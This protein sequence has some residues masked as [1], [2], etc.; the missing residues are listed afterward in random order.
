[1]KRRSLGCLT[2]GGMIAL[3]VSLV[4][5]GVSYAITG[6]KMF[7]PGELNA[8]AT[9][10]TLGGIASHADLQ[11]EC[12]ACHPA[13]WDAVTMTDLCLDCHIDIQESISDPTSLHGA[14]VEKFSAINCRDCHTEHHGPDGEITEELSEDFPHELVGFALNGHQQLDW[15]QEVSCLDCHQ[16]GYTVVENILCLNCHEQV[17]SRFTDGH[18]ELFGDACLDCH[19]GIDTYGKDF[20]HN[21]HP[22]PLEGKHI[23]LDCAECHQDATTLADLQQ[24][25]QECLACHQDR[26]VHEG[27]LGDNCAVCHTPKGWEFGVFDHSQTGFDL[28]GGHA[29]IECEDCHAD[30][31]YQGADPACIA[32]HAEDDQHEGAF[33]TECQTCHNPISWLDVTFDHQGPLAAD[34]FACHTDDKPVDHYPGICSACHTTSAWLPAT[35]DHQIAG[36]TDCVSCH[37]KD[38][39]GDHYSGQCSACHNTG[40]WLPASF[41]HAVAGATDCIACHGN[42]RPPNHFTGQCSMCHS[43]NA[44][45]PASF[46]HTFPLNHGGANENCTLCHSGG[47]YNSYTCYGCHEHTPANIQDK[48]EG[49]ANLNNCVRCHADGSKPEDDGDGGGENGGENNNNNND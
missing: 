12:A 42:Q 16:D 31:T 1:M 6:G 8:A 22:F 36:A 19:D 45:K 41:N 15:D 48:H 20:D 9:T 18:L 11:N 14:V 5:V 24:M 39:P 7:S 37:T 17:D 47:N 34:C 13:F 29:E 10:E 27:T 30:A 35:F 2:T 28:I 26:D 44:W 21:D 4:F 23:P 3:V 25:P 32:C 38:K 33:G 40:G 49:I 43:T 46:K